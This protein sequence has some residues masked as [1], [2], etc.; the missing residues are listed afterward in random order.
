MVFIDICFIF[1]YFAGFQHLVCLYINDGNF[2]IFNFWSYERCRSLL[3]FEP[4]QPFIA[5]LSSADPRWRILNLYG[6]ILDTLSVKQFCAA[7]NWSLCVFYTTNIGQSSK[8][9]NYKQF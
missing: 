9:Y 1:D 8:F 4:F 3:A 5:N 2:S 7:L 6:L